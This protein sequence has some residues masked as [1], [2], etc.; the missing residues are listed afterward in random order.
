MSRASRPGLRQGLLVLLVAAAVLAVAPADAE[1]GIWFPVQTPVDHYADTWGAPRGESRTHEGTD[2]MAPQM[3]RVHA[4]E[5]GEIIRARGEDCAADE[6]CSSYYLAVAGDDGRGYFYVHLNNDTPGRPDGCDGLGG[7]ENAFSPRLVEVLAEQGTLAGTRVE[8]GEHLGWVGSSGNAR[9]ADDQLHFEI[10]SD[11][12]WGA[13]GKVNPYPELVE[14]ESAGRVDGQD[15]PTAPSD[16]VRDAGDDRVGTAAALSCASHGDAPHVVLA[17][18]EGYVAALLASPLAAIDHAPLLLIPDS[19]TTPAS[20]VTEINRLGAE[21]ATV[22]GAVDQQALD[23]LVAATGVERVHQISADDPAALSVAV[24]NAVVAAGGSDT[25]VIF[26]PVD[27]DDGSRGW[28]DALMASTLAA[29]A[30]APVLLTE[31]DRLPSVVRDHLAA[32]RP[33]AWRAATGCR[34][35]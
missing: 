11:T 32:M 29:Y 19:A 35:R 6:P 33:A 18:A 31:T 9:C 2:I 34:P 12:D 26:A 27:P 17:P 21:R 10:W 14:A 8:R 25:Q 24:A 5:G 23:A 20:V 1:A 16:A 7:V 13:S 30:Q 4:S 3:H 22:V 15:G 28:P